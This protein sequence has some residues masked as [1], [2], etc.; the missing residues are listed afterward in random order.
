MKPPDYGRKFRDARGKLTQYGTRRQGDGPALRPPIP[1]GSRIGSQ[2]GRQPPPKRMTPE[3]QATLEAVP[4]TG[5]RPI[6]IA[7]ASGRTRNAVYSSLHALDQKGLVVRRGELWYR[8][9]AA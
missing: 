5:A 1:I 4:P 2:A 7:R 9:E 8:E 3:Q 6:E